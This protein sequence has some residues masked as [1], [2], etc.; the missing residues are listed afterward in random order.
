MARS[1]C[2][3]SF[4]TVADMKSLV[5]GSLNFPNYSGG[6]MSY[7]SISGIPSAT[8]ISHDFFIPVMGHF[9]NPTIQRFKKSWKHS[10]D[11]GIFPKTSQSSVF[12]A[13]F[14]E[15]SAANQSEVRPVTALIE[16]CRPKHE[17]TIG[18]TWRDGFKNIRVRI[19]GFQNWGYTPRYHPFVDGF[20]LI[21]HIVFCFRW[22][23]Y[24]FF[25]SCNPSSYWGILWKPPL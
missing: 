19:E 9:R 4:P 24:G 1:K 25:I 6:E 14:R 20:S 10:T 15:T 3:R 11:G 21:I 7:G 17:K 8:S 5:F 22:F 13:P 16:R 23:S 12:L 18:Y 2:L